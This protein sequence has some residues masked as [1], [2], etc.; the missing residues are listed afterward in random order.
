MI[1]TIIKLSDTYYIGVDGDSE[2]KVGDIVVEKLL[3]GGYELFEIHTLNDIDKV[4]QKKVTHSTQPLDCNCAVNK[5]SLW[6][7]SMNL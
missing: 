4:R 1:M 3:T 5:R 6:I 2:I 7:F